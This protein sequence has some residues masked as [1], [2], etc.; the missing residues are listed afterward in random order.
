MNKIYFD[1]AGFTG[2]NLLDKSQPYFCYLGLISSTEIEN[3]FLELKKS[4]GYTQ[5]EVKGIN[6]C[7]S[8]KG[9]RFL[10]LLW[11]TFNVNAKFV[12]HDKKFAFSAKLYEYTYESV[13]QDISTLL[14][15]ANFHRFIATLFYSYFITSDKTAEYY[16]D[17]FSK[18]IKNKNNNGKLE[19]IEKKPSENSPFI[20]FY[21][22]CKN[23]IN[24]I[25]CDV[26][27]SD[28]ISQWLLDLTNTSLYSLLIDFAGDSNEE[29]F[30][31]CDKSKPLLNQLDFI[32]AFVGDKRILYDD[33]FGFKMRFNFN[34]GA[35]IELVESKYCVS[36]QITDCLVS[37][38]YYSL[39]NKEEY[40]SKEIMKIADVAFDGIHSIGHSNKF[41]TFS[42]EETQ[43]NFWL[44]K[45]LSRKTK[46]IKK[47]E[48]IRK[49]SFLMMQFV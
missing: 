34:L 20:L 22:F 39:L 33:I 28:Y 8:P 23:N 37:S 38:L 17:V 14:Y 24:E 49:Y 46:K 2:N 1:E 21:N 47:I 6:L 4:S 44:M 25:A 42:R 15:R 30:A 26:D 40:F 41:N 16:F 48:A 36:V 43:L 10:K 29:I 31:F 3:K 9:Q 32:N 7:K 19:L 18:Y 12:F 27:F 11:E 5:Q 45:E 13:F 35:P